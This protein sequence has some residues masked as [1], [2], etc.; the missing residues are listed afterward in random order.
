MQI[1]V[2]AKSFSLVP[3]CA[4]GCLLLAVFILLFCDG[5]HDQLGLTVR[6]AVGG[7]TVVVLRHG[8]KPS[9]GLGQLTCTGLN[10]ALQLPAV[11][12]GRFGR[13]SAIFAPNPAMQVTEGPASLPY[14]YVRPLATIEPTAIQLGLPVNTQMA[15]S[16][17]AG[18][19][20]AVTAPPY[21][22]ST[23]FIA[24][25]HKYAYKF[26]QQLL[27]DFGQDSSAVPVWN[28]DDFDMMYVFRITQN[29]SENKGRAN[30]TFEAQHEGLTASLP[31]SCPSK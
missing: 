13:A 10:R 21:S 11:L 28:S 4:R 17:V 26:A 18:L 23:V 9:E 12:I 27:S 14:S 6:A 5:A 3:F 8:E 15:F 25:E 30:V 1:S 16:D 24:W 22:N 19:E 7:E 29:L 31:S 2:A 20:H